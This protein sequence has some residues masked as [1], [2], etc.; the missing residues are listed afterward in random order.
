MKLSKGEVDEYNARGYLTKEGLFT[1]EEIA[2]LKHGLDEIL[3]KHLDRPEVAMEK[4]GKAPRLIYGA[5]KFSDEFYKLSRHPRWIEVAR[6]LVG[7][8]V[9]IHQLR[10]NPKRGF[11]GEGFWWHQDYATWHYEDGMPTPNALMIA[12]FLD[13]ILETAGPMLVIPGSHRLGEIENTEAD[14]DKTGYTVMEVQ[15][16]TVKRLADENGI[17]ALTG[18]AGTA[19]FINCNLLHASAGN[20]TPWPRTLLF[21]NANSVKNAPTKQKRAEYHNNRDRSPLVPLEDDCLLMANAPA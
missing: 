15:G 1:A 7:D 12:V 9:Y 2:V 8:E 19:V 21:I 14:P 6:Q 17:E 10:L 20:V 5:D 16:D 18:K 4:N 3:D 11:D 13:D